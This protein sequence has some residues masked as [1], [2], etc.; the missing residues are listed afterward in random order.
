MIDKHLFK[1]KINQLDNK[2]YLFNLYAEL[3]IYKNFGLLTEI[4]TIPYKDYFKVSPNEEIYN[5]FIDLRYFYE[6]LLRNLNNYL[7][8]TN[9]IEKELFRG[10]LKRYNIDLK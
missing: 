5:H 7:Y 9:P 3:N 4:A 8:I 10:I 1:E 6:T 2:D